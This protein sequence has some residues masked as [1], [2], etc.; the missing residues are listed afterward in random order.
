MGQEPPAVSE[1]NEQQSSAQ[2]ALHQ[3]SMAASDQRMHQ[4]LP[5]QWDQQA[6]A[7][8]IQRDSNE[9]T[10]I[11]LEKKAEVRS[12][13]QNEMMA[14][15]RRAEHR[16]ALTAVA[17]AQESQQIA[18]LAQFQAAGSKQGPKQLSGQTSSAN[19]D[20][21]CAKAGPAGAQSSEG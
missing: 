8:R 17:L 12:G 18:G 16:Q 20:Q 11:I 6:E 15:G 21:P 19:S 7:Q 9:M 3:I 13:A 10:T 14:A 2:Q 5:A 1:T 4:H